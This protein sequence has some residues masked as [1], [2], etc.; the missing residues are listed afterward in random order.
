M[1]I[2][3][4]AKLDDQSGPDRSIELKGSGQVRDHR[5]GHTETALARRSGA[6]DVLAC[7]VALALCGVQIHR[8]LDSIGVLRWTPHNSRGHIT[9]T[10]PTLDEWRQ[11]EHSDTDA[12]CERWE[13]PG[14][15]RRSMRSQSIRLRWLRRR[16]VCRQY[17]VTA[18]RNARSRFRS[19]EH[20]SELQSPCNLVC[21]L[22]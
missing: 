1:S 16:N 5:C 15:T 6:D 18:S 14:R 10:A 3:R 17:R 20:T 12:R 8:R 21:R 13:S 22:L 19:E 2:Y 4:W 7:V 9:H 11:S